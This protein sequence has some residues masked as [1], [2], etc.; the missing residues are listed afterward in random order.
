MTSKTIYLIRH[1]PVVKKTGRIYGDEAEIDLETTIDRLT[2]LADLLPEPDKSQW[3]SS[4]VD[5]A[6]RTAKKVLSLQGYGD[7]D[8]PFAPGFREQNFGDLL[9]EKH[10]DITDHLNFIDGKIYAPHPPGGESI[11][12][13]ISRVGD[14]MQNLKENSSSDTL[15]VF[16]HGGTIRAAHAFIEDLPIDQFI[17]LDTPPLCDYKN[18]V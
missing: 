18:I 9:G 5:R 13:L 10:E 12:V 14:A 2:E 16:C 3:Y 11:E 7:V 8:V 17:D 4:G 6:Y 15:V 1:A